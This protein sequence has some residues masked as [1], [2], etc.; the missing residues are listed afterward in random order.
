MQTQ[1]L[2]GAFCLS[3]STAK[4]FVSKGLRRLHVTD[5]QT[6]FRLVTGERHRPA[7]SQPRRGHQRAA[8]DPAQGPAGGLQGRGPVQ[9]GG[10]VGLLHRGAPQEARPGLGPEHCREEVNTYVLLAPPLGQCYF[11]R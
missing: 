5:T 2:L 11:N 6:S 3:V 7:C 9:G 4:R 10:P 8:A 1:R